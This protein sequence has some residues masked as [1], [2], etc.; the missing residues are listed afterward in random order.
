[1][2]KIISFY[3]ENKEGRRRLFVDSPRQEN[4]PATTTES[5]QPPVTPRKA[6]GVI[7]QLFA[8]PSSSMKRTLPSPSQHA[9]NTD[10][11]PRL[12]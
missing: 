3:L 2:T 11:R 10:K 7:K 1:M 12:F 5:S 8:S 6:S 4:P 9:T